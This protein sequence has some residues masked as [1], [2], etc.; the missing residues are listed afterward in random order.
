MPERRQRSVVH[1]DQQ[2]AHLQPRKLSNTFR[3]D[4]GDGG[5]IGYPKLGSDFEAEPSAGGWRQLVRPVLRVPGRRRELL[6]ASRAGPRRRFLRELCRQLS[7][8]LGHVNDPNKVPKQGKRRRRHGGAVS[9]LKA[10][11][12]GAAGRNGQSLGR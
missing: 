1:T 5:A 4:A 11:R 6:G 10:T 2:V 9:D 7:H 12:G 8:H 3:P